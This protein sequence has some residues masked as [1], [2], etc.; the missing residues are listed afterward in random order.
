MNKKLWL[1]AFLGTAAIALAACGGATQGS[2]N[3]GG[4]GGNNGGNSD[5]SSSTVVIDCNHKMSNIRGVQPTCA[6]SGNLECW[7]CLECK[8]YF[9][10]EAG[11][12]LT[13]REE[14]LLDK[15]PHEG[16]YHDA[17]EATCAQAGNVE[18]YDCGM[19]NQYF[20]D[21]ACT[22]VM[23]ESEVFLPTTS[24][25]YTYTAPKYGKAWEEG[26]A[27]HWY[28]QACDGYYLDE[29][30]ETR[31]SQ[32]ELKLAAP[33]SIPDFIVEVPVD[34]KPVVLQLSD[35]Q[36]IDAGQT[37]PGR[38]GVDTKFWA[39]DQIEERCY[40][41][42]TEV[43][44]A[45]KPDFIIITGDVI[46]GEF[47][48]SGTALTSF[49]NFMETFKTP[50][51]PVF[52][53]HDNESK[54]GVDW[55]CEQLEKAEY[56][57]F[58]QKNLTGNGNYS[59]AI[60]Q[61]G[62]ITRTF[63]LLDSNG[64]GNVS[65]ESLA[66]G[67]TTK[68]TGF[69]T[70][71]IQWYTEQITELRKSVPNV[72]ISFAYHIQQAIF[73]TAYEKYGFNQ[74]EKYQDINIDLL[75]NKAESD[76]GYI[77][78]QLKGPWDPNYTVFKGMKALGTDS[79]FV[80]HEHCNNSSVMYDGIRFQYGQKSS[81]YDR[82]NCIDSN[83]NITGGYSKTGTSLIGGTVIPLTEDGSLET[84][85]VYYCGF[86]NGQINWNKYRP[87]T[88]N[89]LQYGGVNVSTAQMWAD[90]AVYA[91]AVEFDGTTA[92]QVTAGSQGKLYINTA[93]LSGKTKFTFT[94]Y[95]DSCTGTGVLNPFAIRV[96]PDNGAV[97]NIPGGYVDS[98]N[99]D[100]QYIRFREN[101]EDAVK[102]VLGQWK[103]YTV[104]ISAIANG[105]TEFSFNIAKGNVL[106]LK[107]V[108]LS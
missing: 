64:C 82:F 44:T 45:T 46:Y 10:D 60:A 39:T 41:Y 94:L 102:I 21:E 103:T 22:I 88:V 52:G 32:A 43:I 27:E 65:D 3:T 87:I 69:M 83:G 57:Y 18:Y 25:N 73:E 86:E 26:V 84:P 9:L 62:V 35:T 7:V 17:I 68:S 11:E 56:C 85:Y 20:S 75:E 55:Q 71:Q 107:D 14:I 59:V 70:D 23:Q 30:G 79:I 108:A 28:C 40:D 78:R 104:D 105:C 29:A 74:S 99:G 1:V 2:S 53:N 13:A 89:G 97:A 4:N 90:G 58:E 51:S 66:N 67:H 37:R 72:K 80:G 63:Y 36:I 54:K 81:E 5:S 92:Y 34:K 31:V 6:R 24:H 76:F 100:K 8:N 93:L 98:G 12:T 101:A 33:Y 19:C 49:I 61:G 15:L 106:Y 91:E 48:D 16:N 96:K 77:G 47:D 42:L 38:D 50:W 95:I